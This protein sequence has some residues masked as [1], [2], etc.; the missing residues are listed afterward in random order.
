MLVQL[1]AEAHIYGQRVTR[2]TG[3][4]GAV[5]FG[6]QLRSLTHVYAPDDPVEPLS[7]ADG[8][9]ERAELEPKPVGAKRLLKFPPAPEN[10]CLG[11]P[12]RVERRNERG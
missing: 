10:A 11:P 3:A 5:Q 1:V 8:A 9:D 6:R 12:T 7:A 2:K 4:R